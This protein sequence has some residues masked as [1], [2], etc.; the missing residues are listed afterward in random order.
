MLITELTVGLH[1]LNASRSGG[2]SAGSGEFTK[3]TN[4]Y[5]AQ[6]IEDRGQYFYRVDGVTV[7]ARPHEYERVIVNPVLYYF[8]AALKL[9]FRV[10]KA[11][12]LGLGLNWP[13][14]PAA[15]VNIFEL[16]K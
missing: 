5:I 14:N 8:S 16:S 7:R 13:N 1:Q 12:E 4:R 6:A 3:D 11:K 9:H 10:A 2:Y 15:P